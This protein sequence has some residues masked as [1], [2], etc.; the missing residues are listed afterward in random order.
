MISLYL[1]SSSLILS[2]A[3]LSLLLISLSK[4]SILCY[5]ILVVYFI[6]FFIVSF[7]LMELSISS[8]MFPSFL[9]RTFNTLFYFLKILFIYSWETQ[10]KRQRHN[11]GRSRLPVESLIHNSIPGPQDHELSQRQMLNHWATQVPLSSFV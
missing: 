10:R 5:L 4:F 6:L 7:Y 8:S 9:I 3:V 11:R 2:L 1:S